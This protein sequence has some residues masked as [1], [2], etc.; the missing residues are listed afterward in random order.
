MVV[1]EYAKDNGLVRLTTQQLD[2]SMRR[3]LGLVRPSANKRE[4]ASAL[5]RDASRESS[6][7]ALENAP[8]FDTLTATEW[9][10]LSVGVTWPIDDGPPTGLELLWRLELAPSKGTDLG[11]AFK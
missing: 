10:R 9:G 4:G 5:C 3:R 11:H 2:S 1:C 8:Q 6:L 7:P